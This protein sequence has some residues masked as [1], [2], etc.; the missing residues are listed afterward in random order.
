MYGGGPVARPGAR[1]RRLPVSPRVRIQARLAAIFVVLVCAPIVLGV[2]L[3]ARLGVFVSFDNLLER[4][5]S[6]PSAD[7]ESGLVVVRSSRVVAGP[8]VLRGS[9]VSNGAVTLARVGRDIRVVTA[10]FGSTDGESLRL[11]A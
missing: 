9:V 7:T 5:G 11:A 2:W 10:P 4:L 6:P 3:L 1:D 8:A